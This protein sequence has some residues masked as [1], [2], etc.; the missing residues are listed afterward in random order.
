LEAVI[1]VLTGPP[2][3]NAPDEPPFRDLGA[4]AEGYIT[5]HGFDGSSNRQIHYAFEKSNNMDEF[6]E[7]LADKG[8]AV[9]EAKWLWALIVHDADLEDVNV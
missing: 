5:A 4:L 8:M 6:V 3:H 1:G 7:Y 2:I 9:M